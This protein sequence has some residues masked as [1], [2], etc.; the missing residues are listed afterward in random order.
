MKI[1]RIKQR[2]KQTKTM[3]YSFAVLFLL[4]F[5]CGMS[6]AQEK[7]PHILVNTQDRT[8]ILNKIKNHSW[9]AEIFKQMEDKLKP[10]VERH[11]NDPEWILSRYVMNRGKGKQ[12][13]EFYSDAEG[14]ALVSYAGNAP[15]PTV[16]VAPHKRPP[17]SKDG[18][19][20]RKPR[21]EELVP[22]DS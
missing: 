12:Y 22:Y 1:G 13:T 4:L 8:I 5:I 16:R 2:G 7:H 18:Y 11:K 10:Y 19:T 20:F 3:K 15:F 21:I 14:T 17:V 6:S 9:A